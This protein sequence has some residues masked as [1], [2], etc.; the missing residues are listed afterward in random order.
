MK[1]TRRC[2][3]AVEARCTVCVAVTRYQVGVFRD[4]PGLDPGAGN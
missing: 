2:L 4:T 1:V 3:L